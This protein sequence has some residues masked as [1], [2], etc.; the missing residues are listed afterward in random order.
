VLEELQA[1][2]EVLPAGLSVPGKARAVTL[3]VES[4]GHWI[5]RAVFPLTGA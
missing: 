1:A 3:M 4:G 5:R 2:A